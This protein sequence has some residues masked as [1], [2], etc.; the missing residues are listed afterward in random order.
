MALNREMDAPGANTVE[1]P[2]RRVD[3]NRFFEGFVVD[4]DM[5]MRSEVLRGAGIE[6][7]MSGVAVLAAVPT[8]VGFSR[9]CGRVEGYPGL[10]CRRW[11]RIVLQ[12]R[13]LDPTC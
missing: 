2:L 3:F 8:D 1:L 13:M 6:D 12:M 9:R 7:P 11:L 10:S 5:L 4:Q